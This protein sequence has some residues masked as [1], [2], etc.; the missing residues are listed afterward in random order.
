MPAVVIRSISQ[1]S[2]KCPYALPLHEWLTGHG[3]TPA[4]IV[5]AM[6][7]I[8][9]NQQPDPMPDVWSEWGSS[10]EALLFSRPEA[11]D[12]VARLLRPEK[13]DCKIYPLLRNKPVRRERELPVLPE[14][15]FEHAKRPPIRRI[16]KRYRRMPGQATPRPALDP[17][18]VFE[19]E[20]RRHLA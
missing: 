7:V 16:G 2:D 1:K 3:F 15:E 12:A 13:G 20:E 18:E 6:D 9:R 8:A 14:P 17:S 4:Q 11:A 10:D 19:R 5:D